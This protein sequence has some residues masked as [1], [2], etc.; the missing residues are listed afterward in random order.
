MV[1]YLAEGNGFCRAATRRR[2]GESIA[3]SA[4]SPRAALPLQ[5]MLLGRDPRWGALPGSWRRRNPKPW[6]VPEGAARYGKGVSKLWKAG[7]KGLVLRIQKGT[8]EYCRN[9]PQRKEHLDKPSCPPVGYSG[10][11][12]SFSETAAF[13]ADTGVAEGCF[14][15]GGS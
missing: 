13:R 6:L 4:R 10:I 8:A 1:C 3:G 9:I 14:S 2:S 5:V 12:S 15:A 11:F 7:E